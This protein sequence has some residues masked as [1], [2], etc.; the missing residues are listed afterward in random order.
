MEG[1]SSSS[2]AGHTHTTVINALTSRGWCFGDVTYLKSLVTDISSLMGGGNQTGAVV[3]S[4]EAELLNIDIRLVGGKSLPDPTELRRCSH[5][6]GPKVLQ[7][8][9][10]KQL[11]TV[12]T[13]ISY[14]ESKIHSYLILNFWVLA[15]SINL[16]RLIY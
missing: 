8:D 11:K 4:V 12:T 5:L 10:F 13:R 15:N 9:C 6:Q 3:E 7:V 1:A 16:N 2:A 14:V